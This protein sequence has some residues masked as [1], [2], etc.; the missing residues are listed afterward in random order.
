[1]GVIAGVKICC[2]THLCG[3]PS[4]L[5]V[6]GDCFF[7]CLNRARVVLFG[8]V[9]GNEGQRARI[10]AYRRTARYGGAL[11]RKTS[12]NPWGSGTPQE[13]EESPTPGGR[14]AARAEAR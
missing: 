7:R 9:Q 8:A 12:V 5:R 13:P 11:L 1:M 3:N 10:F 14:R 6:K 4:E 2:M